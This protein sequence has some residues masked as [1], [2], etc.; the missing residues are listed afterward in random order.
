MMCVKHVSKVPAFAADEV[1]KT[2]KIFKS[3]HT[4][5]VEKY[6]KDLQA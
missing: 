3:D 6:Q 1:E 2:V 4:K 5:K